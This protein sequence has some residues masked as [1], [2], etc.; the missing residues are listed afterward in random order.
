MKT[1]IKSFKQ[2]EKTVHDCGQ[3]NT[4]LCRGANI[5]QA[6]QGLKQGCGKELQKK[7][8]LSA[9]ICSS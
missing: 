5:E 4:F 8:L 2:K 1:E 9:G 7:D 3:T 6:L